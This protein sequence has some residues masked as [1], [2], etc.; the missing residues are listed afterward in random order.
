VSLWERGNNERFAKFL[1]THAMEVF[2][3]LR[4]PF[5]YLTLLTSA[6]SDRRAS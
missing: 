4:D 3:Y 6:D 1:E 5:D 2:T